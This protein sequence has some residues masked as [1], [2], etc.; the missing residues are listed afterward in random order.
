MHNQT[1]VQRGTTTPRERRSGFGALQPFAAR[2]AAYRPRQTIAVLLILT[3]SVLNPLA[4]SPVYAVDSP[5]PLSPAY[6]TTATINNFPPLGIPEL[7][8]TPVAGATKYRLQL[9][10][11]IGFATKFEFTTANTRYTPTTASQ[12]SDGTWYWRV[13]VDAPAASEYSATMVFTKQWASL[14][15]APALLSPADGATLD[16][17][18]QPIF[19][20]QSVTGAASYKFQV[21]ASPAGFGAPALNQT[22]LATTF[23]PTTKLANATY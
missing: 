9:S 8:W 5:T 18:D 20:W 4:A 21:A 11:D 10:P 6:G 15:N 2:I 19:S 16:F 22:T 17:Y 23:Q 12:F 7:V 14:D 13:R 3:L 1:Q